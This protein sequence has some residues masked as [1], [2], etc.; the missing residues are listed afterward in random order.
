MK[1]K[2]LKE[3][4]DTKLQEAGPMV[5]LKKYGFVRHPEEDFSDDGNRFAVYYYDPEGTGDN[6]I[7]V[8]YLRYGDDVYIAG[9]S[10]HPKTG[11]YISFDDLNGVS[12]ATA[13]EKLPELVK[14]LDAY[15]E[16]IKT[17]EAIEL[18]DEQ[19]QQVV[20]TAIDIIKSYDRIGQS[21]YIGTVVDKALKELNYDVDK[22]KTTD[23]S[24]LFN[25]VSATI[26]NAKTVEE[27][28]IK[29]I[30]KAALKDTLK[31]V[32]GTDGRYDHRGRWQSGT[33]AKTLDYAL[34]HLQAMARNKEGNY[35]SMR[36]L[37]DKDQERIKKWIRKKV[38][39][40]LDDLFDESL[41]EAIDMSYINAN[42]DKGKKRTTIEVPPMYG[43]AQEEE[44]TLQDRVGDVMKKLDD[45]AR[46]IETESPKEEK[47]SVKNMYTEKTELQESMFED[48]LVEKNAVKEDI[49]TKVFNE[50]AAD[51]DPQ[52][53]RRELKRSSYN[54]YPFERIYTVNDADI[55]VDL[56]SEK[57]A[58]FA[59]KVADHYDCRYEVVKT[60]ETTAYT[61]AFPYKIVIYTS[62]KMDE[63]VL[64][65]DIDIR[66]YTDKFINFLGELQHPETLMFYLKEL[67]YYLSE[68]EVKDFIRR[69]DLEDDLDTEV[70]DELEEAGLLGNIISG[71]GSTVDNL[72]GGV[73]G[74][75]Q[76]VGNVLPI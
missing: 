20:D 63:C 45:K 46:E 75:I 51:L 37:P 61:K 43:S 25:K 10:T 67:L 72:V 73:T 35:I 76:N 48:Y 23:E 19:K 69:L 58:D 3:A 47:T 68:D 2:K 41:D 15:K 27:D 8:S 14:K 64:S 1:V 40:I 38:E 13:I 60:P 26:R 53:T 33:S 39:P 9:R 31:A 17:D 30:A 32:Q 70:H 6:T 7:R 34:D 50:L 49:W 65:E 62:E 55:A 74:A 52:D 5:N 16:K 28:V 21:F 66:E 54:R 57:D 59:K 36:D 11:K 18:T 71:V 4:I 29:A 22:I 24:D 56:V 12:V 42:M 44:V